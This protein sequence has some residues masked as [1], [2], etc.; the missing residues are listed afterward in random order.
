[1][2]CCNS[3]DADEPS[4]GHETKQNTQNQQVQSTQRNN[5][6][7]QNL[8]AQMNTQ[9]AL[10]PPEL[11]Q[12][13]VR[14]SIRHKEKGNELFAMQKYMEAI[15]QYTI[16][17]Q[18][19]PSNAVFHQNKAL[20]YKNVGQWKRAQEESLAAL[21]LDANNFK[22][23][24]VLGI[25][26][27]QLARQEQDASYNQIFAELDRGIENVTRSRLLLQQMK[28]NAKPADLLALEGSLKKALAIRWY[29][30][31]EQRLYR[32]EKFRL[33]VLD[34]KQADPENAAQYDA[35]IVLAQQEHDLQAKDQELPE[36]IQC[37]ITFDV[38][39]DPVVLQSGISYEQATILEHL[40]KNGASDPVTRAKIDPQ[41][42]QRNGVLRS[43]IVNFTQ[44]NPW[45]YIKES[46]LQD[47]K[48]ITF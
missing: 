18:L 2:G 3:A 11:Q 34:L 24:H 42:V 41:R 47:I 12:M 36:Y 10:S 27:I 8:S 40:T 17:T 37:P 28:G 43:Y 25:S 26:Q 19:D 30:E 46:N 22:C 33:M 35:A 16:A 4:G 7:K 32:L 45:Y 6:L 38:M 5:N 13:R 21:Q 14:Q 39:T 1:M 20:C 15:E 9:R 29:Y 31:N 44:A 48:G 23:Y